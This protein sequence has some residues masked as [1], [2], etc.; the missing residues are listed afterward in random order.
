M[1]FMEEMRCYL[2]R[3]Y[4]VS[5]KEKLDE[6]TG[7][8]ASRKPQWIYHAFFSFRFSL[9]GSWPLVM[10]VAVF[11]FSLIYSWDFVWCHAY[12]SGSFHVITWSYASSDDLFH[13]H[14]SSGFHPNLNVIFFSRSKQFG[15]ET[16]VYSLQEGR[17]TISLAEFG[18]LCEFPGISYA[19]FSAVQREKKQEI[20]V[21]RRSR[22][23]RVL[24]P[25]FLWLGVKKFG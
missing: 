12:G 21:L 24:L 14:T 2:L 10:A 6:W 17:K 1:W 9:I 16:E 4:L 18:I 7:E 11:R 25:F 13:M 3:F 5:A 15:I 23:T 19:L 22:R 20:P 8:L